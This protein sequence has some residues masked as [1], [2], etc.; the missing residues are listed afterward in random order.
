MG[1]KKTTPRAQKVE[2]TMKLAKQ[3][4]RSARN[5]LDEGAKMPP[6]KKWIKANVKQVG[7]FKMSEKLEKLAPQ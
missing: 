2:F 3:R 1:E 7:E 5:M 6:L 4:Y